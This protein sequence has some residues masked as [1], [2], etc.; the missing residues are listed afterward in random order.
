MTYKLR[1][2]CRIVSSAVLIAMLTAPALAQKVPMPDERP[3]RIA[4][5]VTDP[6]D[7]PVPGATVV[8]QG[9]G[10]SDRYATVANENG[11]FELHDVRSGIPY[12]VTIQAKGFADWSSPPVVLEPGQYKILTGCKLRLEGVQTS[13]NVGY[14]PVEVATEQVAMQEK[15]RIL[16]FIPNFYVNYD[17]DPAPLTAKLKFQLAMKISTDPVTALGIGFVAGI[18][19]AADSPNFQQGAKGYGQR[20]GAVAAN[21][22]SDIMIGG[23]ILPSLLH[24]DP[25]YFYQGTGTTKSRL[26]HALSNPFVCRATTAIYSQI[27]QAWAA[28]WQ[29][30]PFRTPIIRSRIAG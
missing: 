26:L 18:R 24:Q 20:F 5:T 9:P 25:R 23:A 4:A 2:P 7:D 16:G 10:P 12:R 15:Q 30:L 19:Q 6:N 1:I 22:F 17:R 8:L 27:T 28:T 13:V 14:S 3:G 21:G 11:Y 29:R